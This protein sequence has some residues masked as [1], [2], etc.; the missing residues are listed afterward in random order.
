MAVVKEE[1][2][3]L[4]KL[5]EYSVYY[6]TILKN[7]MEVDPEMELEGSLMIYKAA[8]DVIAERLGY[9]QDD[10]ETPSEETEDAQGQK[11]E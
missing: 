6:N 11:A 9:A 2:I 10:T 8:L 5:R 4:D 7:C 1:G 3:T